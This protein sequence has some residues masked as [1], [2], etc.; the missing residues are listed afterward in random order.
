MA[1][2]RKI[3]MERKEPRKLLVQ[4]HLARAADGSISL[5]T[6]PPTAAGMVE[7]FLARFPAEDP[8]LLMLAERDLPYVAD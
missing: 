8:E 5:Q 3:V 6:F 4:P 2:A 1:A 7:A